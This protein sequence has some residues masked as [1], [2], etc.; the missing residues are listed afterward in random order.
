MTSPRVDRLVTEELQ[1]L[2]HRILY[3]GPHAKLHLSFHA[4]E[5]IQMLYDS[6]RACSI[7]VVVQE[8]LACS[9]TFEAAPCAKAFAAELAE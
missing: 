6:L 3:W 5:L 7:V 8:R 2:A 9:R 4:R 1:D